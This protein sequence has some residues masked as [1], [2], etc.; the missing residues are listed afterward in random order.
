MVGFKTVLVL[1]HIDLAN[2]IDR[3]LH[4]SHGRSPIL[5]GQIP[6]AC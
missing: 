5:P 4:S 6:A 2:L 1:V 3:F